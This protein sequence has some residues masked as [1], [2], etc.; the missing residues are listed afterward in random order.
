MVHFSD[1]CLTSDKNLEFNLKCNLTYLF[2]RLLFVKPFRLTKKSWSSET[3][4]I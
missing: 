3:P 1:D 4:L 2:K